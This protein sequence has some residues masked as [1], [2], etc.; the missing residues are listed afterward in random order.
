MS[1]RA[2]VATLIASFV[3]LAVL[4]GGFI[5]LMNPYGNLPHRLLGPHVMMDINQRFQYPSIVRQSAYD[6]IV[7]GTSTSRLL[8]PSLLDAAFGGWFANLSMNSAMAWE[9]YQLAKLYFDTTGPPRTLL[10][11][12]DT[13]WCDTEADTNRITFRGFPEWLY[14]ENPVNDVLHMF[15]A[16]ALEIA[17][18][19]LG[20]ILG[21]GNVRFE[22][23]GFNVFTPPEDSYDIDKARQYI[24]GD[25][26]PVIMPV[27]PPVRLTEAER[28]ALTF[29]ALD[30]LDQLLARLPD[31]SAA[32]LAFMPVHVAAQPVPGSREAAVE[33]ECKVRVTDVA[34][35]HGAVAV[36]F[37]IASSLTREDTNFWD[38]LHYRLPIG[39]DII[40]ALAA[41][42]A[43]D[44][45]SPDSDARV[46]V[47][48]IRSGKPGG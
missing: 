5:A 16:K 35:R 18:R 14:D 43:G 3:T 27:E 45:P 29:P 8:D 19:R 2:Y 32:V 25:R 47:G 30:W 46:L 15:N 7:I 26:Q 17:G 20:H 13:V 42:A 24:W 9:Q 23:S 21:F 34:R 33:A 31:D 38:N 4:I 36:D 48:P 28:E 6:S 1:W 11:G 40:E 22:P 39:A 41:V 44:E 10:V 12:L 37:R